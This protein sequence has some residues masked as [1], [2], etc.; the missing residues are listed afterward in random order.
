MSQIMTIHNWP[1]L[2][3]TSTRLHYFPIPGTKNRQFRLR[4]DVGPYLVA[5]A[6]EYNRIVTPIDH[7]RLDDWSWCPLRDGRASNDPSD[8]CAGVAIDINAIGS[9]AQGRG[10]SWWLRHPVKYRRLRKLLRKFNLLE[11]GGYYKRFCDPMHFTF[12]YGV[13]PQQ[14]RAAMKQLG[15]DNTGHL[16]G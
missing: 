7:G 3:T 11:W 4:G 15:I 6:A 8:H 5:F 2:A 12:N 1:V 9:G 10:L 16:N 14:V 13:T